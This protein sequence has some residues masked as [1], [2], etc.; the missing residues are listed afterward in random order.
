MSSGGIFSATDAP[1][2]AGPAG[3]LDSRTLLTP[4]RYK[5]TAT[6]EPFMVSLESD[7][8][9]RPTR[10]LIQ[11]SEVTSEVAGGPVLHQK[12]LDYVREHPKSSGSNVA[13][14]IPADKSRVLNALKE[15]AATGDVQSRTTLRGSQ[16][17][18]K[19]VCS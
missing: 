3:K 17:N 7:D 9:K 1:I 2:H 12:I 14:G 10:V 6:P 15:L 19:P 5:F 8:P 11:G 16:H 18:A 13:Q 4:S